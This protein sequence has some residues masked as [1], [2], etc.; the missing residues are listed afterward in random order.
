MTFNLIVITDQNGGISKQNQIPWYFSDD[1]L[2]FKNK[3][4]YGVVIMGRK[5]YNAMG[6]P[7]KN[8]VNIIISSTMKNTSDYYVCKSFHE[9]YTFARIFE[10]D[11]WV[12]GGSRIYEEAMQH[13]ALDKIYRNV[14]YGDFECDNCINLHKENIVYSNVFRSVCL[15]KLDGTEYTIEFTIGKEIRKTIEQQY[16]ALLQKTLDQGNKRKT[17]SG[18]TLSIFSNVL[19]INLQDGFPLLTTKKMFWKGI[20]EELLF[21][22][23]GDTNTKT[24]S[25]KGVKIWEGNT[26]KEFLSSLQ[27]PYEEGDM[28]PMYGYQ[29]RHFNKPYKTDEEGID[30]LSNVIEE[31]KRDPNSRRLLITNFNPCQVNEGVLYPCHSII[32]QFY[33]EEDKLSCN[34]Y[35]RSVD[36]FLG[37]PFNIAS[38]SL[39]VHIIAKLTN[40]T[41]YKVHLHLGDCHIYEDHTSQVLSQLNRIPYK[42]C[43]LDIPNFDTLEQVEQSKFEDYKLEGYACHPPIIAKMNV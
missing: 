43:T 40:L 1:L 7:L 19:D 8:R 10:R 38:T 22:I 26:T 6:K 11:I 39:L 30:Q 37:L 5:T 16:L 21:F 33:I 4:M 41:A 34:M 36:E 14:I 32:L 25:E 42:L 35:Q 17:R 13:Y 15:N 18:N 2:Y 9:A 23:R 29:W 31:I 24:L 27:L 3:T 28:G 12:I 20:V